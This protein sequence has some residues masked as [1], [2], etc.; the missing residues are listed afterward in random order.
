MPKLTLLAELVRPNSERCI[1]AATATTIYRY[2][3]GLNAWVI[4]GSGFSANARRWQSVPI[5]GYMIFNNGVDLPVSYRVEDATVT[6]LKELREVGVASVKWIA[7]YNGFL[8]G[9]NVVTVIDTELPGILAGGS[10]YG[11]VPTNKTNH[12]PYRVIWSEFGEPTN[13]APLFKVMLAGSTNTIPLPFIPSGFIA[14]VT[15]VAVINGGPENTTLG[16]D[17]AHPEGILI[18]NI[19]GNSIVLEVPTDAAAGTSYPREVQITRWTDVSAISGY[20]DLQGDASHILGG[21]ALHSTLIIYRDKGIYV[22]RYTGNVADPFD[23]KERVPGT[24]NVPIWMEAVATVGDDEYHLY[25]GNGKYF[26]A[27]DGVNPPTIHPVMD[28]TR[29]RFFAG[30]SDSSD[31][32]A[33]NNPMTAESWFCRPE[34]AIAFDYI[35][36]TASEINAEID[37]AGIVTKPDWDFDWFLLSVAGSVL[38]YGRELGVPT[39]FL[40]EGV[41]PGGRLV[42]GRGVIASGNRADAFNEKRLRSYQL[43]FASVQEEIAMRLKLYSAHSA[44]AARAE[45]VNEV[46]DN[47]AEDGGMLPMH[48]Q[49]LYFQDEL[50]I[51]GDEDRDVRFVGRILEGGYVHSSGVPRNSG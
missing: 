24:S 21:L 7:H 45:L 32:W 46:I 1:I 47:P 3:S 39:T 2:N 25:P 33:T 50:H 18:T 6:P 49:A 44:S 14:G 13:W 27:F 15:R 11:I 31:V 12:I 10:P 38:I 48:F 8:F 9:M 19:V 40:R 34:F 4:I 26:F 20:K 5:N 30:L 36:R 17:T 28:E 37:S 23:W 42:F 16:G 35:K 22:A 41:N 29:K 51:E 43:H